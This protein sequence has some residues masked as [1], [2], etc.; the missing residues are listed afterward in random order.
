VG[1]P[2]FAPFPRSLLWCCRNIYPNYLFLLNGAACPAAHS[3]YSLPDKPHT[4]VRLL[5]RG[6][7]GT[8][9]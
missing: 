2:V 4:S 7:G 8:S 1:L 6:M 9:T 5:T 3:C